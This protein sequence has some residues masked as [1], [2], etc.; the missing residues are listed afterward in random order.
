MTVH[1]TI[2]VEHYSG[3][4]R[5]EHFFR[6]ASRR[7]FYVT[8]EKQEAKKRGERLP[9]EQKPF[10]WMIAT[11]CSETI[12]QLFGAVPEQALGPGIYQITPGWRIGLVV[13][14]ELPKTLDTLWLRGLGKDKILSEA[15]TGIKSLPETKRERNDIVEVCIKHFKY[16]V[17]K[18]ATDL[19][20]EEGNFMKTMQEIDILYQAE[21]GRIRSAGQEEGREESDRANVTGMLI[22]RFGAIDPELEMVIPKLLDLDPIKRAQQIMT[23]SRE[24]LLEFR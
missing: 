11:A 20:E 15:F 5:P 17:E 24:A 8:R 6:C 2:A 22:A 16:L 7:D 23:L 4:L 10:T 3:Y 1:P 13:V 19:S 14:R 18:S 9:E 21:M 12:L